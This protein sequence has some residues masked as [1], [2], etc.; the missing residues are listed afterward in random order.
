M[1]ESTV[2]SEIVVRVRFAAPQPVK[3][4]GPIR[5]SAETLLDMQTE[6][7]EWLRSAGPLDSD[8]ERGHVLPGE[9]R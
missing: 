6:D 7:R 5:Y 8:W 9:R 4:A 2:S 3:P 1:L